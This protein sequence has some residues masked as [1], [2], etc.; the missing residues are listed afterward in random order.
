V[1][2]SST[3]LYPSHQSL[4][5]ISI[6]KREMYGW[7]TSILPTG[8]NASWMGTMK[9]RCSQVGKRHRH[10]GVRL[11]VAQP[12]D[13]KLQFAACSVTVQQYT[14]SADDGQGNFTDTARV[15]IP[16]RTMTAPQEARGSH[17]TS[18]GHGAVVETFKAN[19]ETLE[20]D[21]FAT[22]PLRARCYPSENVQSWSC[23]NNK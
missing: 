12:I 5:Q 2:A 14:E 7:T 21:R 9:V 20:N 8:S 10:S 17:E 11:D 13:M 1:H 15:Q 18:T 6:P 22:S 19:N 3:R 16:S 23:S 4:L